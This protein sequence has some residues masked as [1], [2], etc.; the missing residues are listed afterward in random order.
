[1]TA[2]TRKPV[3]RRT[4]YGS[5]ITDAERRVLGLLPYGYTNGQIATRLALGESTVKTYLRK[6]SLRWDTHTRHE[7]L[8][9]AYRRGE[10]PLPDGPE[11]LAL[12]ERLA[13]DTKVRLPPDWRTQVGSNA[14]WVADDV[15]ALVEE[16]QAQ[17]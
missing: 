6:I 16:W 8:T 11:L 5:E 17:A 10:L 7:I 14:I 12:R 13:A 4:P 9:E 3:R 15:I 2:A 1:M